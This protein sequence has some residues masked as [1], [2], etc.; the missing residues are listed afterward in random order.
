MGEKCQYENVDD[1]IIFMN[2]YLEYLLG[3]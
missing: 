2:D 3:C 1:G